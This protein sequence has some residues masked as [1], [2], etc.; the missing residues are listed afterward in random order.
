MDFLSLPAVGKLKKVLVI[1]DYGSR[2]I[3][4]FAF[5]QERSKEVLNALTHMRDNW[6]LPTSI[7][8]N[9]GSHFDN[10]DVYDFLD[11]HNIQH[12][13]TPAYAPWVNGLV[14]RSNRLI[15]S[16]L[17]KLLTAS[18]LDNWP[19]H[20]GEA[21]RSINHRVIPGIEYSPAQILFG[22]TTKTSPLDHAPDEESTVEAAELHLALLDATR[23]D[24]VRTLASQ[25]LRRKALH[26]SKV[27]ELTLEVGDL[28]L[29][30]ELWLKLQ[31]SNKLH[32]RWSGPYRVMQAYKN[33]AVLKTL[34]EGR[35]IGSQVHKKRL[36]CF[37]PAEVEPPAL[38]HASA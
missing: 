29:R 8:T 35:Q 3:W 6:T 32:P 13:L 31:W 33:L 5:G 20:L 38:R 19:S 17:R 30:H 10:A 28:V 23:W 37:F 2:Y 18:N 27:R 4:A 1:A 9:N 26:D 21:T 14:K 12:R 22:L 25:Q 11:K 34:D 15:V 24:A 36:K 16:T 7:T